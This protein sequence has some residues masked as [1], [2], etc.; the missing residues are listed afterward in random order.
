MHIRVK[1]DRTLIYFTYVKNL[2][3]QNDVNGKNNL[4]SFNSDNLRSFI[5]VSVELIV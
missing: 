1:R 4:K 3:F 5:T 2:L